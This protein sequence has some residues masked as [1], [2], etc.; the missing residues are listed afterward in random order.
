LALF[1]AA[2]P[3][4]YGAG[5]VLEI[6]SGRDW[7]DTSAAVG[8]GALAYPASGACPR[9][10]PLERY[11]VASERG[12]T[13]SSGRCDDFRSAFSEIEIALRHN[14]S[15]V[16]TFRFASRRF[17]DVA[18]NGGVFQAVG[19]DVSLPTWLARVNAA[20]TAELAAETEEFL[21]E[22]SVAREEIDHAAQTLDCW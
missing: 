10:P 2:E 1:V 13:P 5:A 12:R 14:E 8:Q 20:Q 15:V 6:V 21:D 11:A 18:A 7:N 16:G 3:V 17:S 4:S 19:T 22:L 9:T